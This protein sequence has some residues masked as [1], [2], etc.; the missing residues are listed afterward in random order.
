MAAKTNGN[1]HTQQKTSD[2]TIMAIG[3]LGAVVGGAIGSALAVALSDKDTRKRVFDT[4]DTIR[5]YAMDTA[6][7]MRQRYPEL[8]AKTRRVVDEGEK[9]ADKFLLEKGKKD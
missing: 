2:Q 8:K 9:V 3:V 6:E 5:D 1:N 7:H 4:V